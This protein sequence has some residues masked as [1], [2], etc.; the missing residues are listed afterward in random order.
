MQYCN[1]SLARVHDHEY[2]LNVHALLNGL[3]C[4]DTCK[5]QTCTNQVEEEK[6]KEAENRSTNKYDSESDMDN[7]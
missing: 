2:C 7:Q 3:K 4:T 1:C 5:L 6:F